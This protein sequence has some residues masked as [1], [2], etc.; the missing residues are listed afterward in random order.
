MTAAE[1]K[2]ALR[3]RH[4]AIAQQGG[5]GP[6]TTLEEWRGI[7][8]LAL[9]AWSSQGPP[10]VGYE[11]KVSRS[12]YRRELLKP[13][14]RALA[15][16]ICNAFYFAVPCGLLTDEEK[17]FVEPEH[18]DDGQAF[19][20]ERCPGRCSKMRTTERRWRKFH[21]EPEQRR[22]RLAGEWRYEP[23]SLGAAACWLSDGYQRKARAEFNPQEASRFVERLEIWE[24]CT[25]CEGRG[26]MRRS[27][28]EEEAPTLW[29][30]SDVGLIEIRGGRC[31]V[32]R[33]APVD[34]PT[35]PLGDL[36]QLLRWVSYRPDPRHVAERRNETAV[37]LVE[38]A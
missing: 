10:I 14:K 19:V 28:V 13:S 22:S 31:F 2:D 32:V 7:D 37:E 17:A 29:I 25:V 36:G 30:P 33:K 26:Y 6:W 34:E 20:R 1:V 15:V 9:S 27:V 4:P 24:P 21:S 3:N 23:V 5:P 38:A 11:V 8:L 12:D 35:E 18:F 16:A